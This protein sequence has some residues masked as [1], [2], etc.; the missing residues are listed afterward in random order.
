QVVRL[1]GWWA[2]ITLTI[3][4]LLTLGLIPWL[5]AN[6]LAQPTKVIWQAI[7]H[8]TPG[9]A[10]QIKAPRPDQLG[11]GR[12]FVTN[13]VNQVYQLVNAV[14]HVEPSGSHRTQKSDQSGA[15]KT[16]DNTRPPK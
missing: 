12:E 11:F 16:V 7:M 3:A 8:L 6:T 13:L 10:N 5:S 1:T 14:Q 4:P 15:Q 2:I 9:A